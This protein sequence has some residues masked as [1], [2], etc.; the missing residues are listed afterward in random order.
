MFKVCVGGSQL[1][2][3]QRTPLVLKGITVV[4][5]GGKK[6]GVV[7]RTGSGKSTLI[8]ALFRLVEA[9]EG[10]ILID[11]VNIRNLG[12]NDL[13]SKLSII[14]QDPNLF[15][16]TI[17]SN[18][19][20]LGEHTDHEIWHALEKCQLATNVKQLEGKLDAPVFANG[21][22]WSLGQRQLFCLGRVLLRRTRILV[23]DEATASVDTQTDAIM[24]QTV[25]NEFAHCTVI[26]VA[27]RIPS[28]MDSDKVLV[29]DAGSVREYDSPSSLL[30][31][32]NSMFSAL[33]REYSKRAVL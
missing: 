28:V 16:G 12:L 21:D 20:P 24:R 1:R 31:Q 11:D 29:L 2:Y 7:G 4:I 33:V 27:H 6:V 15:D 26:S 19:D 25:R 9:V 17:R 10:R 22:N 3:R 5:E 18:L 23:L 8:Y 14:P 30:E 13:R 32:P